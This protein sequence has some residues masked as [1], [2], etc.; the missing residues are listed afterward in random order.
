MS[1]QNKIN[2]KINIFSPIAS[3]FFGMSFLFS[4]CYILDWSTPPLHFLLGLYLNTA[5]FVVIS[6]L[7][8]RKSKGGDDS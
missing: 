1:D 5:I 8:G 3:L 4:L 6:W 2:L 7:L